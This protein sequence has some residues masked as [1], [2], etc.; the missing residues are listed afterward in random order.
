MENELKELIDKVKSKDEESIRQLYNMTYKK[1]Y[2]EALSFM[3]NDDLAEEML[4]IAYIKIFNS[5]HNLEDEKNLFKWINTIVARTCISELRK[6]EN[7]VFSDLESYS[8]DSFVVEIEDESKEFKPDEKMSFEEDR[9]VILGFINELPVEQRSS[10]ILQVYHDMKISEIAEIFECNENTI[11]SRLNYAKKSLKDKITEYKKKGNTLF[12]VSL[13]PYLRFIFNDFEKG[14]VIENKIIDGIVT[15]EVLKN[16]GLNTS[17]YV[18]K[19]VTKQSLKAKIKS[20]FVSKAVK[21]IVAGSLITGGSYIGYNAYTDYQQRQE[22]LAAQKL[23]EEQDSVK[24][25]IEEIYNMQYIPASSEEELKSSKEGI[26]VLYSRLTELYP[27]DNYNLK[28]YKEYVISD[29]A[30]TYR[31]YLLDKKKPSKFVF[32]DFNFDGRN[33]LVCIYDENDVPNEHYK[34]VDYKGGA[35]IS[36]KE[37]DRDY[38]TLLSLN[39]DNKVIKIGDYFKGYYYSW[40]SVVKFF[41]SHM[42]VKIDLGKYHEDFSEWD[43]T[44]VYSFDGRETKLVDKYNDF[45]E[46]EFREDPFHLVEKFDYSDEIEFKKFH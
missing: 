41:N 35:Y 6:K 38:F 3:K 32:G 24:A 4:Q 13:I 16:T 12:S 30:V 1:A 11:K 43:M 9:K 44:F 10:L 27:E 45:E 36:S 22:E 46:S 40:L 14:L 29:D 19:N 34:E 37:L 17:Q 42:Y 15:D 5:I 28:K 7:F 31:T 2:I 26:D 20:A 21:V 33:D 18:V 23:K 8:D 39:E 25:K